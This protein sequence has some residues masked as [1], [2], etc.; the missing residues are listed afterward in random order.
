MTESNPFASLSSSLLARKGHAKP[1]MRP[2]GFHVHHE[3]APGDLEDLGWNDMGE[4]PVSAKVVTLSPVGPAPQLEPVDAPVPVQQ[5]EEIAREFSA[6]TDHV[7]LPELGQAPIVR[8][9]PGSKAKAAFT[10]RL[11]GERHLRLRLVCAVKHR[12]AQQIVTQALDEFLARQPN[13]M[14]LTRSSLSSRAFAS[15]GDEQ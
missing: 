1:A 11:D 13:N 12:S 4:E 14:D 9:A 5:Q 2:Q 8:A 7:E 6:P 3:K 15:T 10:L